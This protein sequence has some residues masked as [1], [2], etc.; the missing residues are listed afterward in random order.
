MT[1]CLYNTDPV[2]ILFV[3]FESNILFFIF[4]KNKKKSA[5]KDI[6][7]QYK[8]INLS[9]IISLVFFERFL[10]YCELNANH[11]KYRR[12]PS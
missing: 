9:I 12:L 7:L 3:Q 1:V 2:Y 4:L 8:L 5:K 6:Q 10:Y 11:I